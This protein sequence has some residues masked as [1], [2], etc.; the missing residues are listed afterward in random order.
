M[1]FLTLLVNN[2]NTKL[3]RW[4]LWFSVMCSFCVLMIFILML[5]ANNL[6]PDVHIPMGLAI[7]LFFQNLILCAVVARFLFFQDEYFK[8]MNA[9]HP[10]VERIMQVQGVKN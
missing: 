10:V 2:M 6:L 5:F 4:C 8:M 1:D 3:L 7:F 9:F